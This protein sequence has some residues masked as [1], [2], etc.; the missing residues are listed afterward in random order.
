MTA[1]RPSSLF[2]RRLT[3]AIFAGWIILLLIGHGVWMGT[4]SGGVIQEDTAILSPAIEFLRLSETQPWRQ[5]MYA[6]RPETFKDRYVSPYLMAFLVYPPLPSIMIVASLALAPELRNAPFLPV[7]LYLPL[8]MLGTYLLAR[9]FLPR[10]YALFA[11]MITPVL[12]G[13]FYLQ[14]QLYA[15][16]PMAV[17]LTLVYWAWWRSDALAR[18]RRAPLVGVLI[19]TLLLIKHTAGVFLLLPFFWTLIELI[20]D[21]WIDQRRFGKRLLGGVLTVLPALGLAALWYG[22]ARRHLLFTL[23]LQALRGVPDFEF[24]YY[25]RLIVFML[26]P[27]AA[28]AAAAAVVV[29][30]VDWWKRRGNAPLT[31]EQRRG[32][33]L[34]FL[35]VVLP[36]TIF[37]QLPVINME[38]TL[39]LMPALAIVMAAA[40]VR[41]RSPRYALIGLSILVAVLGALFARSLPVYGLPFEQQLYEPRAAGTDQSYGQLIT[42]LRRATAALDDKPTVAVLPFADIY[43]S[44]TVLAYY[45][46][47][48]GFVYQRTEYWFDHL[49]GDLEPEEPAPPPEVIAKLADQ[50]VDDSQF[51]KVLNFS[52]VILVNERDTPLRDHESLCLLAHA[53]RLI[54][55]RPPYSEV[56]QLQAVLDTP[57]DSKLY[58]YHCPTGRAAWVET[59][60]QPPPGHAS[61]PAPPHL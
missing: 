24:L 33:L 25:P 54:L 17:V 58:V 36:V 44:D 53:A 61:P 2:S 3:G 30:A 28:V 43:I 11:A 6:Q 50:V 4:Y 31:P 38:L 56:F 39:P 18:P 9:R 29:L 48:E 15:A 45:A 41:L 52:D 13:C 16:Y 42:E 57:T 23:D 59:P 8:L 27:V 22:P 34:I 14:R 19:G 7:M 55:E 5:G 37:S 51:Q 40:A 47:R 10:E 20:R 21:L 60:P 32:V 49:C 26:G 35:W 1:N 46:Y 12:P